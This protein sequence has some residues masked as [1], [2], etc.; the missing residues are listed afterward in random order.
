[1]ITHKLHIKLPKKDEFRR[2]FLCGHEHFERFKIFI[3]CGFV[4]KIAK[5]AEL[6]KR[7]LQI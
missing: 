3:L 7:G 4:G 5:L 2:F 1:M 6:A